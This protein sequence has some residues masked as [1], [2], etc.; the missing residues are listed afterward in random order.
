M[1]LPRILPLIGIAV[2]GVLAVKALS[3]VVALPDL[4]SGAKAFA[5]GKV[6]A[7]T[8]DP[9]AAP[10]AAAADG[11]VPASSSAPVLP[12][13]LTPT[14]A[15]LPGSP[16]ALAA[17]SA[18]QTQSTPAALACGPDAKDLA[19]EAGLSPAELQ[20]LQSLGARRGQLDQRE[21]DMDVQLQLL[22][23]AESKLDLKLKALA[24]MKSDIQQLLT[25]ADGKKSAE[26]DRLVIVYSK[27]KPKD[28]AVRMTVLDDSVRI[29]IA[30]KMKE[31]ALSQILGLMNPPDAKIIT[32]KLASRFENKALADARSAMATPPAAAPPPRTPPRP[33]WPRRGPS[34][35]RQ[36]PRRWPPTPRPRRPWPATPTRPARPRSSP[37]PPPTP[38]ARPPRPHR[39]SPGKRW[40]GA[41]D[42][43][44]RDVTLLPLWEK[45]AAGWRPDEGSRQTIG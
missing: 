19:R 10:A 21:S 42:L 20:I 27:M 26:I 37:R 33:R 39:P 40:R 8:V 16:A 11:S 43:S 3:G 30:A 36:S 44:L 38:P 28:A 31:S 13:G 34:G 41:Q 9:K 4:V 15:P 5:E 25:Q 24:S 22:A 6:A 17:A 23:A 7:K 14:G 35:A 1:N 12:P 32:E 45:V 18:A 2:G 29:P